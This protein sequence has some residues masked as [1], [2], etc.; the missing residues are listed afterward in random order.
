VTPWTLDDRN[1]D[2]ERAEQD[3]VELLVIGGGIT[4]A[5]VLRDAAQRGLTALLVEAEDF[6]GGTSSATSK[7]IHG[8]LRYLAEG[9]LAVTRQSCVERDRLRSLNPNLVRDLPFLFCAYDDGVPKWKVRLGLTLYGIVAGFGKGKHRM[10]AAN[11]LD[12]LSHDLRRDGLLAT[13][14]YHDAQ[15]DDARFVLE[16][17]KSARGE[18]A[19]AVSHA[20]VI[21]FEH[22]ANGRLAGARIKDQINGNTYTVRSKL[23]VNATG[24]GVDRIRG[25]DHQLEAQELRPAKGVHVVL[26]RD[27]LHADAAVACQA[28]D[29]RNMFLCPYHDVHLI[30]TTDTFTGED[31]WRKV[32]WQEVDYLLEAVNRTFPD[33]NLNR[34]DVVS[35]YAGVRPLVAKPGEDKPPSSVS[36][37]HR[38]T[39]DPSGLI[40]VAGGKLTT[41]RAMAEELVDRA[42]GQLASPRRSQLKSCRTASTSLRQDNFDRG[43]LETDLAESYGLGNRQCAR[44]VEAWGSDALAMLRDCPADWR[45]SI[46][47]SR[48][49]YAEIAWAIQYECV[50]NLCDLLEHRLRV[51]ALCPGQGLDELERIAQLAGQVSGWSQQRIEQEMQS[52]R[53]QVK[54][55]YQVCE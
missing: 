31:D 43:K 18:G 14:L 44:L 27:R 24:P 20:A 41:F 16:V 33:A 50:A 53:E 29:G 26:R 23:I 22:L 8:G 49:I 34:D 37:E 51:A 32:S 17:L 48:Y 11:E 19:Q 52:Y 46:G 7:M 25:L 15:V 36:R 2:L 4:G 30:G 42:V 1:R 54:R 40:S 39:E 35:V 13:G 5:G 28:A 45:E 12:Q 6:A 38:I 21:G 3:G 47:G 55:R 10:V 9:Q